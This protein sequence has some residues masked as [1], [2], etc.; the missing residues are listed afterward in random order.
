L[1]LAENYGHSVIDKYGDQLGIPPVF[2][3]SDPDLELN[4]KMPLDAIDQLYALSVQYQRRRIG[5]A[6]SIADYDQFLEGE[7]KGIHDGEAPY[8][9]HRIPNDKYELYVSPTDTTFALHN[10][11]FPDR[12]Y[13][14]IRIAGD[15][16]CKHLPWYRDYIR[17]NVPKEELI[18]YYKNNISSSIAKKY[19]LDFFSS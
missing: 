19:N 11:T 4:P 7:G 13:D 8:W 10:R 2:V 6:L 15:F 9:Q 16:T 1:R 18:E 3:L 17:N 5:L 12:W 14:N